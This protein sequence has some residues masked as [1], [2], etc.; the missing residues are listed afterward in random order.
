MGAGYLEDLVVPRDKENEE[1][2]SPEYEL[3]ERYRNKKLYVEVFVP[4]E[5][6]PRVG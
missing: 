6:D 1:P 3:Y 2:Y 4:G 5:R